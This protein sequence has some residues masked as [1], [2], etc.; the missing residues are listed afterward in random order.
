MEGN[1]LYLVRLEARP[2]P[3]P[4][5][6]SSRS[7][8]YVNGWVRADTEADA[9]TEALAEVRSEGWVPGAIESVRRVGLK[10][11]DDEPSGREYFEP[12]LIEGSCSSSTPGIG[13]Q[14]S[15]SRYR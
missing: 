10:D 3:D 8:A 4:R 14:R 1:R 6:D 5:D 15:C 13:T 12:A 11:Y 2:G 7:G 9:Q